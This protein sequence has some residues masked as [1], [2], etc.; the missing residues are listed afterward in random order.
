MDKILII[1]FDS[2]FVKVEALDELAGIA[3]RD[4]PNKNGILHEIKKTTAL[5]MEGKI[6][7]PESLERRFTLLSANKKNVEELIE[8]L[9]KNVSES[10]KRNKDFFVKNAD[11]IYIISGGFQEYICPVAGEYGIKKDHVLAN[12][13]I[14][15]KNGRICGFDKNC[16]LAK[17]NGKVRQIKEMNL[18]GE[19][20][21]IGD[22]Y[23]DYEIRQAGLASKFIAYCENIRR[24][25]VTKVADRVINSFDEL[26]DL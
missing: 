14:F 19:V 9:K 20:W 5:G 6:S 12:K 16:N 25:A 23:T 21:V 17:V 7:F 10:V 26:S 8:F 2:T 18:D 22:G 3:L 11:N 15:D 13:F 1:D 4:N 24:E